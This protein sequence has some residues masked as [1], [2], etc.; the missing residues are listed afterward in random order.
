MTN[1]RLS[2]GKRTTDQRNGKEIA[3]ILPNGDICFAGLKLPIRAPSNEDHAETLREALNT[4]ILL[5]SHRRGKESGHF[6][7]LL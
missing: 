6:Q 4:F 1:G 2:R 5:L 3:Q 7:P